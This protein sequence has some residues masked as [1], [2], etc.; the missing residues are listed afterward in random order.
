MFNFF[1]SVRSLKGLVE[2]CYMSLT[3]ELFNDE[4]T[5][6]KHTKITFVVVFRL[7]INLCRNLTTSENSLD[8]QKCGRLI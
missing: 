8:N 5:M 6:S 7:K 2:R 1:K 3:N 4:L